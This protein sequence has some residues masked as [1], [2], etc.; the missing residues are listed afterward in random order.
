MLI[1]VSGLAARCSGLAWLDSVGALLPNRYASGLASRRSHLDLS[2][3]V[4]PS[5]VERPVPVYP[6]VGV[7]AE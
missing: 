4:A 6:P 3:V 2:A 7:G 5:D 1:E